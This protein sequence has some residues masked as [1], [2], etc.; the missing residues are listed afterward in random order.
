MLGIRI[1]PCDTKVYA[2]NSSEP[3]AVLGKFKALV[4]SKCSSI[5]SE[6]LVVDGKTSLLGYTTATDLG[7]LKIANAVSVEGNVFLNYS[8]LFS[9]LGKMKNV[10]IKLH[11]DESV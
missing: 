1:E 10:V 11:V 9:G 8:G 3:L 6:F 7:I 5:N 4:E 2:F